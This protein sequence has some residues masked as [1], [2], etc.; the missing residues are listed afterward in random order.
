MVFVYI[1]IRVAGEL[2]DQIACLTP[3]ASTLTDQSFMF[4]GSLS[5]KVNDLARLTRLH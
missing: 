4:A 5:F 3:A 1:G 2:K